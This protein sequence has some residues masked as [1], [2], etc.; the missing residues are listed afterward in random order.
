MSGTARSSRRVYGWRGVSKIASRGPCSTMRPAYITATWSASEATTARSWLTYR[1]ATPWVRHRSRI[2][3]STRAW[4]VTSRPVVGSSQTMTEGRGANAIAIAT[5]CCWPPESWCGYRRRNA[6]SAGRATSSSASRP[7]ACREPRGRAPRGAGCRSGA[8][9]S[10]PFPGPA[11]CTRPSCRGRPAGRGRAAP[12][13]R[14]R[15]SARSPRRSAR[16]GG[17]GRAAP[18]PRS[19]CPSPDSPTSPST[20]P[21]AI[22]KATSSTM[23]GRPARTSSTRRSPTSTLIGRCPP[24]PARSRR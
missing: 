17:H 20:W 5:R 3:S 4:V 13:G 15:R 19:S 6:G 2:V 7:R 10:A 16:R 24:T 11:G 12:A 18:S 21:G 9:G 1:P 14:R 8:P 22:V 23:S